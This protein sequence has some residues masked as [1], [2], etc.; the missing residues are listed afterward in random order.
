ME[1]K[2]ILIGFFILGVS[3]ALALIRKARRKSAVYEEYTFEDVVNYFKE[4]TKPEGAISASLI[5]EKN[6]GQIHLILAFLD[7]DGNVLS[8]HSI[9][10]KRL[11]PTLNE[12][13]SD[14]D[15]LIFT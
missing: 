12:K 14:K 13:L 15:V 10:T 11:G 1:K 9:R 5:R 4:N 3:A 7:K 8:G 2:Q 6:E